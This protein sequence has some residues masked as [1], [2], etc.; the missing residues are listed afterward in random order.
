MEILV[1]ASGLGGAKDR[2]PH[3]TAPEAGAWNLGPA[4]P[5][6]VRDPAIPSQFRAG[7]ANFRRMVSS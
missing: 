6:D 5:R 2:A 3:R 1:F 7:K 4:P